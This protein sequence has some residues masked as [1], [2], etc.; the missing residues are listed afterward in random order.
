MFQTSLYDMKQQLVI[1]TSVSA[2]SDRMIMYR[3]HVSISADVSH[4]DRGSV[5]G[6]AAAAQGETH[7]G[8]D[9]VDLTLRSSSSTQCTARDAAQKHARDGRLWLEG[10]QLRPQTNNEINCL[11]IRLCLINIYTYPN[12]KPTP[13]DN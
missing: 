2:D 12:P 5:T 13:Y 1:I 8:H 4:R 11:P 6:G 9:R 3:S 10:I 7:R